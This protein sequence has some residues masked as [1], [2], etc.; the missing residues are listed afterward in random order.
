MALE[1]FAGAPGQRVSY[2]GMRAGIYARKSNYAGK[3]K[4]KH[5]SVAEQLE[6]SHADAGRL[7]VTVDLGCEYVDDGISASRYGRGE[8]DEFERL[9]DDIAHRR[10][11]MVISWASTRLQRDLAV[12]VRLRDACAA[13]GVLLVYGGRVYDMASKDDRFRTGLDALVGEREVD[14]LRDN[15]KRSLRANAANGR[16]HGPTPYGYRRVYDERTGA[17][18]EVVLQEDEAPVVR[19]ICTRYADGDGPAKIRRELEAKRIPPPAERWTAKQVETVALG[20]VRDHPMHAEIRAEANS[21]LLRD[22]EPAASIAADFNERALPAVAAEWNTW[23]IKKIANDPRYLGIRVSHGVA[24]KE[25]AWPAIIDPSTHARCLAISTKRASTREGSRPT[26]AAHWLSGIGRCHKCTFIFYTGSRRHRTIDPETGEGKQVT[27]YKCKTPGHG[28]TKGF[29]FSLDV[30]LVDK[31]VA[32]QMFDWLSEPKWFAAYLAADEKR[33]KKHADKQAELTI[34]QTR[35]RAFYKSAAAGEISPAALA[36]IE[37]DLEPK[38]KEAE[39]ELTTLRVPPVVKDIAVGS[40]EDVAKAWKQ[41]DL[42]Q[43][44][45]IAAALLDVRL[46]SPGQGVR[47]TA[48]TIE[49]YV[50]VTPKGMTLGA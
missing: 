35:L 22:E 45:L 46:K 36:A 2:E 17:F 14:E 18:V 10:L 43:Q 24:T 44:R 11:D 15:V 40:R 39:K 13:A 38:I 37:D 19:F 3:K 48:E 30:E 34:L 28:E 31:Y 4:S 25:N 1:T 41:L 12:Y 9:L 5:R 50:V 32:G 16:P 23:T 33:A 26:A 20:P 8:R 21:R 42:E 47:P 27:Q 6:A 7:G 29:H 49:R